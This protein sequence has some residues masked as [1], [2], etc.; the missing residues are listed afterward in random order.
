MMEMY[1]SYLA[2]ME[3]YISYLAVMGVYTSRFGPDQGQQGL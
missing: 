3:M 1:I 2:V